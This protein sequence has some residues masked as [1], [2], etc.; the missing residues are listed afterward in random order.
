M[1]DEIHSRRKAIGSGTWATLQQLVTLGST[2]V[3]S[4]IIAR[5]LSVAD[6]G[7]F[8]YA[9]TLAS[10]GSVVLTAGLSALAIKTLVDGPARQRHTMTALVIIRELFA[11][12]GYV[13]LLLVSLTSGSP[14][15]V[16]ITAVALTVLFARGFDATELWFQS[17]AESGKTAPIRISVVIAMLT[18]RLVLFALEAS[19]LAYVILYVVEAFVISGLLMVKYLRARDSPG[20]AIPDLAT[21]RALLGMSWILALSSIAAQVNSRGDVIVI[22]AL[23]DSTSVGIYSAAARLSEMTYFLPV[24]FMTATFPRLLQIRRKFGSSSPQYRGE[25]QGSYDRAC[26]TGVGIAAALVLLGPWILV[27]LYGA[28]YAEAGAII[29]V[30]AIALPFVFMAAVFSKW[31]VAENLLAASLVRHVLGAV[32][33]IALN[34][35]L[36]PQWGLIGSAWATVGSY[37]LASFLSC[38]V[39]RSTRTAGVQMCL[40]LV[41][42][43]RL[44]YR[45]LY[46]GRVR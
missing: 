43:V 7:V 23:L 10:M 5:S 12:V 13:A 34:F 44:A 36:I 16:G 22:Q 39:T 45:K 25:L 14:D 20:F 26:W 31:I 33:N 11:V 41:A 37:V 42:P 2:A 32:L 29:Q 9:T 4:I 35:L 21:P 8:S 19:L 46:G 27:L 30:H 40:A 17:R 38:F 3:T 6:F 24:V 18:M 15:T 1:T 28:K